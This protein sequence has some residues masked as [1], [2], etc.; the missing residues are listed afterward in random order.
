MMLKKYSWMI[1]LGFIL[2]SLVCI[3]AEAEGKPT[4]AK[5][6]TAGTLTAE[7]I[8]S[9]TH[10]AFFYAGDDMKV[11]VSMALINKDGKERRRELLMLRKN[12]PE[13][14]SQ[15]YFIYFHKPNDVRRTTFMVWKYPAKDDD[16]WIFIPAVNM[17][18]RIAAADSR[19]SFVG[20]DFTYEDVSGRDLEADT[21][22]L[23]REEKLNDKPCYVIQSVPKIKSDS[24]RKISWIDKE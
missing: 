6:G 7:E 12:A 9:K 4:E 21:H 19:S 16:R 22:T 17:V 2:C 15:K 13:G 10:Q 11:S 3:L 14:G 20:S 18:R 23:L 8:M 24:T 1:L 5:A